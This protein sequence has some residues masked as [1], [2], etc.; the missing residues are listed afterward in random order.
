MTGRSRAVVEH[1]V[2][3]YAVLPTNMQTT[4]DG[5]QVACRDWH[6]VAI[7]SLTRITNERKH[8]SQWNAPFPAPKEMMRI[9]G[10]CPQVKMVSIV[11][12]ALGSG[13]LCVCTDLELWPCSST[14]LPVLGIRQMLIASHACERFG[15]GDIRTQTM[16]A[17]L[18]L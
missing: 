6:G 18:V 12:I 7:D 1:Y 8:V 4:A 16:S 17:E 2:E 3:C 14:P 13:V 10:Q 11:L 15:F 5:R 9:P